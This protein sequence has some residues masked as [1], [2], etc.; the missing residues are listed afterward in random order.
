ME[1]W[2]RKD[3]KNTIV[4]GLKIACTKDSNTQEVKNAKVFSKQLI[5]KAGGSDIPDETNVRF[6]SSQEKNFPEG[7]GPVHDDILL[8]KLSLGQEIELEA[9]CTKGNG[10][11]H[12]KWSPVATAWYRLCPEVVLLREVTGS[13]AEELMR[14]FEDDAVNPFQMKFGKCV[15][16]EGRPHLECLERVRALSAEERWKDIISLRKIKNKFIFVVESTGAY[17]PAKLV[18]EALSIL[19]QKSNNISMFV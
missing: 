9:H 12:A 10:A 15:V 14:Q 4:L 2:V 1:G 6:T 8:A 11:E 3:Q 13:D 5:W 18:Q 16:K 17:S 19:K 7:I